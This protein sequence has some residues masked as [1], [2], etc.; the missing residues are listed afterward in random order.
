MVPEMGSPNPN[1]SGQGWTQQLLGRSFLQ[2]K[3]VSQTLYIHVY[4][5]FWLPDLHLGR[6]L[7]AYPPT[8]VCVLMENL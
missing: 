8:P 6:G 2:W 3:G 5:S 7:S 1:Q 4:L